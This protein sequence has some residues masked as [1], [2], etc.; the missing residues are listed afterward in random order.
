MG[1]MVVEVEGMHAPRWLLLMRILIQLL[2]AR[3]E[4]GHD[5]TPVWRRRREGGV[6]C[7][8]SHTDAD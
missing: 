8:L 1:V 7:S 3:L 2:V 4:M 5:W 6:S